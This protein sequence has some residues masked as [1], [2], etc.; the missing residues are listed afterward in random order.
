MSELKKYK[1]HNWP[2]T[3]SEWKH[4]GLS[5]TEFCKH[6]GICRSSFFTAFNRVENNIMQKPETKNFIKVELQEEK[7]KLPNF[8]IIEL[9]N[10]VKIHVDEFDLSLIKLLS[11]F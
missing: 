8:C 9:P 6:R 7:S 11:K 1:S 5:R 3:F 10:K 4:S 2:E